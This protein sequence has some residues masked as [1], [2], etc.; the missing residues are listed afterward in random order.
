MNLQYLV[1][2]ALS[3]CLQM[4]QCCPAQG[5]GHTPHTSCK[6]TEKVSS[7]TQSMHQPISLFTRTDVKSVIQKQL[8]PMSWQ[9]GHSV[10]TYPVTEPQKAQLRSC[11]YDI[12]SKSLNHDNQEQNWLID[13]S[14]PV[15]DRLIP[16]HGCCPSWAWIYCNSICNVQPLPDM[17]GQWKQRLSVSMAI[18]QM[19]M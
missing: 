8:E 1:G 15:E 9:R 12:W 10:I 7:H 19:L 17:T 2:R 4:H 5:L 18:A 6:G 11:H 13:A 16:Q 3:S 14:S